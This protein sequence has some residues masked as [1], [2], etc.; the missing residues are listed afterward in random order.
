[1]IVAQVVTI[2]LKTGAA[3]GLSHEAYTRTVEWL[4][5]WTPRTNFKAV[6]AEDKD[7]AVRMIQEDL[8][9]ELVPSWLASESGVTA[10]LFQF[11]IAYDDVKNGRFWSGGQIALCRNFPVVE[12]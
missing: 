1:M 2:S 6:I 12:G 5:H 11:Q 4:K 7:S 3:R 8:Q 10:N 9:R